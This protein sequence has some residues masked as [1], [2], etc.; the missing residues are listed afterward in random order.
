MMNTRKTVLALSALSALFAQAATVELTVDTDTTLSDALAAEGK[1]LSS[2]DTLV[3]KG[4]GKLTADGTI[5]S[6]DSLTVTVSAGVLEITEAGQLGAN[7]KTTITVEDGATLLVTVPSGDPVMLKSRT[8]ELSGTGAYGYKGAIVLAG[9]KSWQVLDSIT[10]PSGGRYDRGDSN[11]TMGTLFRH[12]AQH[13]Q[14][15]PD[16]CR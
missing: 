12:E 4:T 10:Q 1:T 9:T 11:G 3:K 16:A 13:E 15:S 14:S 7:D 2:G 5:T 6:S 8:I